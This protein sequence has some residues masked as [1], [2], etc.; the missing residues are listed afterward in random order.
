[1][2][3]KRIEDGE[4]RE[5]KIGF[6]V[7]WQGVEFRLQ[8]RRRWE[9]IY[10]HLTATLRWLYRVVT[11]RRG[12]ATGTKTFAGPLLTEDLK[13]TKRNIHGGTHSG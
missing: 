4:V 1:M 9:Y 6:G 13:F 12:F 10:L 5:R 7:N 2:S 3:K 8:E 11:A